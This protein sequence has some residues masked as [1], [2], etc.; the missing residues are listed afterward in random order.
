MKTAIIMMIF[1]LSGAIL[2]SQGFSDSVLNRYQR[3]LLENPISSDNV[4]NIIN[5]LNS[6][7]QWPDIDYKDTSRATWQPFVHLD[8][9]RTL[10][11]AWAN[12]K[13]SFYKNKSVWNT[14]SADLNLWIEKKFQSRNWWHNEIGVPQY[15]RDIIILIRN[16]LTPRQLKDALGG[17]GTT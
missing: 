2:K 8:R 9:I 16:D 4:Q 12:P 5:S 11:L 10:A 15:F 13:D 1:L 17:V 14:I 3:S 7:N 6:K